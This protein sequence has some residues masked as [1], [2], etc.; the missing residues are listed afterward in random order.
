MSLKSRAL[1]ALSQR[2]HSRAELLKK[3]TDYESSPGELNAIL[4]ELERK[5]FLNEERHAQSLAR[6]RSE[7]HGVSRIRQEMKSKGVPAPIAE[8]TLEALQHNELERAQALWHK[9]FGQLPFDA[10]SLQRQQRFMMYRGFSAE[11]I[12]Q[13]LKS[14]SLLSL[15]EHQL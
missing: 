2:E 6:Q 14:A 5:G 8:K 4:D 12:R 3:F 9:R 15:A 13:V 11:T 7:K 10:K 1:R